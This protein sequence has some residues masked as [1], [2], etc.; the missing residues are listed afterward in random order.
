MI[1]L[2]LS[3]VIIFQKNMDMD[4]H[5]VY[6]RRWIWIHITIIGEDEYGSTL[7]SSEK[8]NM[9]PHYY[10]KRRWIWI[11]IISL[12]LSLSPSLSHSLS[13]PLSFSLF[14]TTT[15]ILHHEILEGED[16]V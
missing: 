1:C 4:Q 13:F 9:N 16:R 7:L 12:S 5:Y 3:S 11:H 2:E 10:N 14:F 6:Q 15:A 8:M